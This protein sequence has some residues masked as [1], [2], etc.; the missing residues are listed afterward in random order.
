MDEVR[1]N[2]LQSFVWSKINSGRNTLPDWIENKSI[3]FTSLGTPYFDSVTFILD[4][5]NKSEEYINSLISVSSQAEISKSFVNGRKGS[6][7]QITNE[8]DFDITFN[9]KILSE[10]GTTTSDVELRKVGRRFD[11]GVDINRNGVNIDLNNILNITN[12]NQYEMAVL[13]NSNTRNLIDLIYEFYNNSSYTNVKVESLYLNNVFGIYNIIPYSIQ[14][15][16][17]PDEINAYN[18]IIQAY[19]DFIDDEKTISEIIPK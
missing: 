6:I 16:Q 11:V 13:P 17:N 4:E 12:R 8:G 9:I 19:S 5:F 7:K 14:T 3:G 18:I 1:K 15:Q 10:F 2:T